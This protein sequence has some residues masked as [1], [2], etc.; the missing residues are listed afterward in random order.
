VSAF[1]FRPGGAVESTDVPAKHESAT[2]RLEWYRSRHRSRSNPA[3]PRISR[4]PLRG[5]VTRADANHGLPPM[6]TSVGPSGAAEKSGQAFIFRTIHRLARTFGTA[7][8]LESPGMRNGVGL[9]SARSAA[10]HPL[11]DGTF[12]KMRNFK[13]RASGYDRY[14][15]S[16]I[17]VTR[18][19][20]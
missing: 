10:S 17:R 5:D 13:T 11:R 8:Q 16:R 20:M 7:P 3:Q 9:A 12:A 18:Q 2:T 15:P 4:R 6:A 14:T 19:A 1:H